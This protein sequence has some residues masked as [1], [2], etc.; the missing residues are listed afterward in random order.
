MA[1]VLASGARE[2]GGG[3]THSRGSL[4]F[5]GFQ[6]S[7]RNSLF[8]WRLLHGIDVDAAIRLTDVKAI[9]DSLHT[10]Q[11]GSLEAE[12]SLSVKNC[13][14]L[15]RLLQL[16][17]E[18][19]THLRNAHVIL[20]E[21][22]QTATQAADRWKMAARSYLEIS[23]AFVT[24]CMQMGAMSRQRL[25]QVDEARSVL[26][27]HDQRY[28]QQL[29]QLE[30]EDQRS[31]YFHFRKQRTELN[32][33]QVHSIDLEEVVLNVDTATLER[34][35]SNIMY[36]SIITED[37]EELTPHHFSQ[38]VPLAQCLLDYLMFQANATGVMLE[39]AMAQLQAACADIPA[40]TSAT[41]DMHAQITSLIMEAHA[42]AAQQAGVPGPGSGAA[43][44]MARVR[45]G[46]TQIMTVHTSSA[47]STGAPL[48]SSGAFMPLRGSLGS[49]GSPYEELLNV[50]GSSS[51]LPAMEMQT[52]TAEL[53][54]KV[55]ALE[56][57]LR[58]ERSKTD[59]MKRMLADIR[60]RLQNRVVSAGSGSYD[61]LAAMLAPPS[62]S[63]PLPT[64]SGQASLAPSQ[65]P[66]PQIY[67]AQPRP[68]TP[69]QGGATL[70][71]LPSG[72]HPTKVKIFL[73]EDAIRNEE[74]QRA[75]D[76]VS[77][78]ADMLKQLALKQH[79]ELRRGASTARRGAAP[80]RGGTR[81]RL[82]PSGLSVP[83]LR[84]LGKDPVEDSGSGSA[85]GREGVLPVRRMRKVGTGIDASQLPE[86][87]FGR[88]S[89]ALEHQQ[90]HKRSASA[91]SLLQA[92]ALVSADAVARVGSADRPP[93]ALSKQRSLSPPPHSRK[94][95]MSGGAPGGPTAAAAAAAAV[96]QAAG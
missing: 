19:L 42:V 84:K 87:A 82:H 57:D 53:Q 51:L 74:R 14:Q 95:R 67:G 65:L 18:Y 30:T 54:F 50:A 68:G 8:D 56:H 78:Q 55:E 3:L 2:G 58:M 69:P 21:H 39:Q 47:A 38:L 4:T 92:S 85:S 46:S 17:I 94:T 37:R 25:D 86:S 75:M 60:D 10:L 12:R 36:G 40:L 20:L 6:F 27:E 81:D 93:L 48:G 64:S 61:A 34:V 29:D 13:I 96:Q 73:D 28:N 23:N 45:P 89:P 88:S 52:R 5:S 70:G 77:Q 43:D 90:G 66:S 80:G 49:R 9:E 22:Y 63:M 33:Q 44:M 16:A 59:E 62:S 72:Q 79:N 26:E 35:L 76:I 83:N 31:R 91:G 41:Q 11:H 24:E 32:W 7:Y 15:F 1:A 71:A